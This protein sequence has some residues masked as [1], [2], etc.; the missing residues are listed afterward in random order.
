MSVVVLTTPR[1]RT[2]GVSGVEHEQDVMRRAPR[3]RHEGAESM[4]AAE[5]LAV[6]DAQYASAWPQFDHLA[7]HEY[8][9]MRLVVL[10]EQ[11]TNDW[12]LVFETIRGNSL[13][14][15]MPELS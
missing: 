9:A 12:G 7:T 8:Y 14:E 10:Y 3:W 15:T 1:W 13:D 6:L 11:G 4:T 5:I 2:V